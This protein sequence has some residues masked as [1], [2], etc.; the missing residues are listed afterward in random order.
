VLDFRGWI[1][2]V[3]PLPR[4]FYVRDRGESG[5]YRAFNCTYDPLLVFLIGLPFFEGL[6]LVLSGADLPDLSSLFSFSLEILRVIHYNSYDYP[7]P[8]LSLPARYR[9]GFTLC[10]TQSG[11]HCDT[12]LALSLYQT[13]P[14]PSLL[15][16]GRYSLSFMHFRLSPFA[17]FYSRDMFAY[18]TG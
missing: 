15:L 12:D 8:V 17:L 16:T 9:L 3:F 11:W 18:Q 6:G 1:Q 10:N 14:F 5:L 13:I 2:S 7:F 4:Y